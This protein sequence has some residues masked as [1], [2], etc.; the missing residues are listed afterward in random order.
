[1]KQTS[2]LRIALCA[3][4]VGVAIT[5]ATAAASQASIVAAIERYSSKI[6]VAE[7]HVIT[8]VGEYKASGKDPAAVRAAIAK[9]IHVLST[10][11][12]KIAAQSA[13]A[14]PVSKGKAMFDQGLQ[15]VIVAYRRLKTIF[16]KALSPQTAVADAKK[17][18]LEIKHA[19]KE[20]TAGAKLLTGT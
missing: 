5:P 19:Q 8:A 2:K 15:D 14:G 4:I 13:P 3:L 17:A 18:L 16:G 20:L 11:K 1:M 10:L 9:S 7:G 12:A 6:D